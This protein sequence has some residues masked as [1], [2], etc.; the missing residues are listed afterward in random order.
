VAVNIRPT[1]V[2]S[3]ETNVVSHCS[4]PNRPNT[5]QKYCIPDI[6]ALRILPAGK[7][8]SYVC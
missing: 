4:N 7:I 2:I 1:V 8:V 3:R 5:H 6:N